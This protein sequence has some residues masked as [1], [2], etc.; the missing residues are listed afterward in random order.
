M[1]QY[2]LAVGKHKHPIW[3]CST[4]YLW[5]KGGGTM[6]NLWKKFKRWLSE[7]CQSWVV[8]EVYFIFWPLFKG[9]MQVFAQSQGDGTLAQT[10]EM[11]K[12]IHGAIT[13][14]VAFSDRIFL[15]LVICMISGWANSKLRAIPD[16][17]KKE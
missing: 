17:W 2:T 3:V 15:M 9:I 11:M 7:M 4:F 8:L 12:S 16:L 1:H 10:Y 13:E 14:G 6:K 5:K